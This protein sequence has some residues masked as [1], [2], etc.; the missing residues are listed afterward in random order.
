MRANGDIVF[1]DQGSHRVRSLRDDASRTISTIAG[2]GL[3]GFSPDGTL[4]TLAQTRFPAGIT[5]DPLTD[6]VIFS[7][8]NSVVWRICGPFSSTPGVI[9]R[10]VGTPGVR[11]NSFKETPSAVLSLDNVSIGVPSMMDWSPS[12]LLYVVDRVRIVVGFDVLPELYTKVIIRYV[13]LSCSCRRG[14][15]YTRSTPRLDSFLFLRGALRGPR[16]MVPTD[17]RLMPLYIFPVVLLWTRLRAMYSFRQMAMNGCVWQPATLILR[18]FIEYSCAAVADTNG[19][20]S[21]NHD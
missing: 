2:T 7:D 8:E 20:S 19:E 13:L 21:W 15:S 17:L 16:V 9:A 1:A 5:V 12:G 18:C 14:T 11:A 6:E 10:I 3:A 4:A